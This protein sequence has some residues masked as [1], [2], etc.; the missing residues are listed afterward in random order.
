MLKPGHRI[1]QYQIESVLGDGGMAIVYRATHVGM[2]TEHA[3]K[4]LLPNLAMNPK[5]V[6]RFR[7]EA[8]AQFRLRHP[9]IVQVTDYVETDDAIALVMDLVHGMTL[10]AA[11]DL[12]PGPWPVDDVVALMRPVLDAVAFAH[13]KGLDGAAVVHRDLKPEN[14]LLDLGEDR[15]WPGIPKVA[16]FGIAKVKLADTERQLT[17]TN[18]RMGTVPYMPPEQF[19]SAK[20]VDARADVWALGMMLWHMLAGQLP[21][22]STNNLAV[23]RLYEGLAPVP[24]LCQ[25]VPGIPQA[26]SDAVAQ[27]LSAQVAGRFAD[28]GPL[29]RAVESAAGGVRKPVEVP[30]SAVQPATR[31]QALPYSEHKIADAAMQT[32]AGTGHGSEDPGHADARAGAFAQG[33]SLQLP[34]PLSNAPKRPDAPEFIQV[35][36]LAPPPPL[37][38][39]RKP[40]GVHQLFREPR[41]FLEWCVF[42]T[43]CVLLGSLIVVV[44]LAG[45]NSRGRS[46]TEFAPALTT[47]GPYRI[48]AA[49]GTV[50][51]SRTGLTWQRIT[52]GGSYSWERAKSYCHG[53]ALASGGWRLPSKEELE[54]LVEIGKRPTI[55]Q[56]TFPDT[57]P[58]WFWTSTLLQGSRLAWYVNFFY[59][60]A[61]YGNEL[62]YIYRVRCVR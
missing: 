37:L 36:A 25:M 20:D 55:D 30:A 54:L 9:N 48:D 42:A 28:A 24:R 40:P 56:V 18:A 12:R 46:L 58:K 27:A 14:I 32:D 7:Q 35:H 50:L 6:E 10:R 16:D 8:R 60:G 52:D 38:G 57:P 39:A 41:T 2:G 44:V 13:R 43:I 11:M 47:S 23:L 15:T 53:L 4:V 51:D 3:I 21:V 49:A 19:S 62:G 61:S 1:G 45:T 34:P 22:D 29:L 17:G 26:L 31:R 5:T 33:Q 59:G